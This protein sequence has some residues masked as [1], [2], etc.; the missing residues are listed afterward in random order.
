MTYANGY[1]Y[2]NSTYD[3]DSDY[4][5]TIPPNPSDGNS[6]HG[7]GKIDALLQ[8]VFC[9]AQTTIL[10]AL[11]VNDSTRGGSDNYGKVAISSVKL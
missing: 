5:I 6:S 10:P 11:L 1:T 2:F 9:L 7:Q 8:Q 3:V 4:V